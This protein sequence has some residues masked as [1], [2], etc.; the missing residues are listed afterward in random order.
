[1]LEWG[2]ESMRFLLSLTYKECSTFLL[3]HMQP[4]SHRPHPSQNAWFH[5]LLWSLWH[6]QAGIALALCLPSP[7]SGT[8]S[9]SQ[10]HWAEAVL[11]ILD[12]DFWRVTDL[13]GRCPLKAPDSSCEMLNH[14]QFQAEKNLTKLDKLWWLRWLGPVGP[15]W[16]S[17]DQTNDCEEKAPTNKQNDSAFLFPF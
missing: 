10:G 6:C 1:M 16:C 11:I 12:T 5:Q 4:P 2:K 3:S 14:E 13:W 17:S 15:F 9:F 8:L 7:G